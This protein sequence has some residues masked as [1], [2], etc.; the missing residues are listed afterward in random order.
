MENVLEHLEDTLIEFN[1]VVFSRNGEYLVSGS[2]DRNIGVWSVLRG[3]LIKILEEHYYFV[4]SL[5]FS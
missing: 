3:E 1:S 4:K 2:Y 5:V